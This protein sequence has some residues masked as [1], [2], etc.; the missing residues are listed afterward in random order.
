MTLDGK[1]NGPIIDEAMD[2]L[3]AEDG[4]EATGAD[5]EL[6]ETEGYAAFQ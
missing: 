4:K 2:S 6:E 3:C 5:E 1:L